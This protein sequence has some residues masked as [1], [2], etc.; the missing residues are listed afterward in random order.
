MGNTSSNSNIPIASPIRNGLATNCNPTITLSN[1][2][3]S[4][5]SS[6]SSNSSN[7]SNMTTNFQNNNI[8]NNISTTT[9][10]DDVI[11]VVNEIQRL[12]TILKDLEDDCQVLRS[13]IVERKNT[14]Q[15]NLQDLDTLHAQTILDYEKELKLQNEREW[16]NISN[17]K[18]SQLEK[19]I[20]EYNDFIFKE[21]K[22][23][24]REDTYARYYKDFLKSLG[25]TYN[26]LRITSN[27]KLNKAL[28][29]S[30]QELSKREGMYLDHLD[31][32]FEVQKQ[33]RVSFM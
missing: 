20:I 31:I 28:V 25:Q 26:N 22:M 1:S 7:H 14:F 6:S 13:E 8:S 32:E 33:K 12:E 3:H 23:M 15:K 4:S 24:T 11:L 29:I 9:S 19:E 27:E 2:S 17:Y 5:T 10:V 18:S 21:R 30:Q 16:E